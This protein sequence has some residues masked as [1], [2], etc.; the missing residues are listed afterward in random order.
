MFRLT[1]QFDMISKM[2]KQM[3]GVG[4]KGKVAAM[5]AQKSGGSLPGMEGMPMMPAGAARRRARARNGFQEPQGR[6]EASLS[7]TVPQDDQREASWP[8][9]I[10]SGSEASPSAHAELGPDDLADEDLDARRDGDCD[11][12]ARTRPGCRRRAR[13]RGRLACRGR[14]TC[15]G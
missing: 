15:L 11:E 10:G 12:Q 9:P 3:S 6:Q 13:R 2:S 4:V 7:R 5:R 8:P 14:W 1:K